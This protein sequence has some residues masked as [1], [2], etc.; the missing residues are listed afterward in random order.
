MVPPL[1]G[2][3]AIHRAVFLGLHPRLSYYRAFSPH[4]NE[5]Q[6][7]HQSR[8]GGGH[9]GVNFRVWGSFAVIQPEALALFGCP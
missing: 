5:I 2:G 6:K 3:E 4:L 8:R 9:T 1:Q 7:P